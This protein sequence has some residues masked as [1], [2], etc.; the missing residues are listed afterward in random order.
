MDEAPPEIIELAGSPEEIERRIEAVPDAPA[1]FA[2]WA[3][4]GAPYLGRTN[5]LRRRL[6]RLLTP[7]SGTSRMLNLRALAVR[8][9]FWLTGSRLESA[10]LNY[11]LA[12]RHFP[13]LY[14]KIVK[15]PSPAY[16]KVLLANRFP[17][18][19]VTSKTSSGSSM[20]FGP[21]RTRASAEQFQE[22]FLNLFQLRR[23][24]E[25]L[26]P[27]PSHPGC[28][29]GE[30]GKCLRPCQQVVGEEEYRSEVERVTVFLAS[31]GRSML[32]R[33]AGIRD[34]LSEQLD[35][36]Q[37]AYQHSRYEKV[38][39]VLALRDDLAS[40]V[41]RIHGVCITPSVADNAVELWFVV[42]GCFHSRSRFE[43]GASSSGMVPLDARLRQVLAG[44]APSKCLPRHR[45]ENLA[46][47][48]RWYHASDCD[49]EW[50]PFEDL[51]QV[52][53][54]K[55]VNAIHRVSARGRSH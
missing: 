19:Q 37:A 10:V 54:R 7:R 48:S 15:L 18:C 17:R 31:G 27:S 25:D 32:E 40:D 20:Y 39:A 5:V 3:R 46:L 53:Y 42:K 9:E 34:R 44:L 8:V 33:I 28:I 23:C 6:R 26:D 55:L 49:G 12:R 41:R 47:L 52:P 2:V 14:R 45:D 30:M 35:F 1:V 22:Q 43:V 21:F 11:E 4:E 50:L 13:D 36:E 29:Y 16:V 38:Q 51:S 24:T